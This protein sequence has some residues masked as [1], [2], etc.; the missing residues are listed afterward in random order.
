MICGVADYPNPWQYDEL[1]Q[2]GGHEDEEDT[3]NGDKAFFEYLG[4]AYQ[5]FLAGDDDQYNSLEKEEAKKH[6]MLCLEAW[7]WHLDLICACC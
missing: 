3:E 6:G 2:Q 7:V 4:S 5:V 1:V